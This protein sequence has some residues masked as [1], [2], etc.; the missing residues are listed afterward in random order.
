MVQ[1][2]VVMLIAVAVVMATCWGIWFSSPGPDRSLPLQ[3]ATRVEGTLPASLGQSWDSMDNPGQDGWTT[4]AFSAE[5]DRVLKQ[6][7]DLLASQPQPPQL[8]PLVAD[9]FSCDPLLPAKRRVVFQDDVLVVERGI[10]PSETDQGVE[11]K[12]S[13]SSYSGAEGLALALKS[14]LAPLKGAQDV[15]GKFKVFHVDHQG[16]N[17]VTEQYVSLSGKTSEAMIEQNATW[18]IRWQA[19]NG[20]KPRL[21]SI[22]VTAFEQVIH[23]Q[24]QG[25][26]FADCTQSVLGHNPCYRDQFLRGMNNWLNRSQDTRYFYLLGNPGVAVGDVNGDGLDDLYVCQEEGL[27]NRLFLQSSDGSAE[28]VSQEW[29]VNWLHNSRGVL[30]VDLD[31]DADQDLVVAMV[32]HL[33]VASNER[34][35]FEIRCILPTG[36]DTM[37]LS[38]ADYDGD[39]DL[40]IYVC[41]YNDDEELQGVA[42]GGL[43]GGIAGGLN[44]ELEGGRNSLFRN[45]IIGSD[46]WQFTD[47]TREVGLDNENQRLS[48]AASWE[49]YDN[50]ADLDLYVANDFG[51]NNL[52]RNDGGTFTDVTAKNEANDSAFGM[53]I[54]WSDFDRNGWMDAYVSNMFSA[55]GGRVTHQDRFLQA[56][57]E[58]KKRLQ[59]FARGN[60]LLRNEGPGKAFTD[61]SEQAGVAVG[62]W[63]WSSNFIDINNDGWEDLVVANGFLTTDDKSDL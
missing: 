49:D 32:G 18:V 4:E 26:I 36:E 58:A 42:R 51:R 11:T 9:S 20:K 13:A 34:F 62:R 39:G 41:V 1:R 5:A 24:P 2:R 38:A 61:I 16:D 50:D 10:T 14:L 59:R 47:V 46:E 40:D 45:Q 27:P 56:S 48:L 6:L 33:I 29:G 15:R 23:Q 25:T 12:E 8:Q 43:L 28:D 22:E 30:L 19:A 37:S 54:T 55:A 3:P 17:F 35:R 21:K 31:N 60:T 53:S 63:A 44:K 7:G 52:F 57:P